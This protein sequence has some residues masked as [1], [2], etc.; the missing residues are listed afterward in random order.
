MSIAEY[1][2]LIKKLPEIT[3]K[4]VHLSFFPIKLIYYLQKYCNIHMRL[5]EMIKDQLYETIVDRVKVEKGRRAL[6]SP[7]L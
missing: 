3:Q 1:K 5:A 7:P 4:K 2:V 6:S